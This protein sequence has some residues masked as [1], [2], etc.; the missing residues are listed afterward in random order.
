M[1][2]LIIIFTCLS[3]SV[4][5]RQADAELVEVQK[6]YDQ[7]IEQKDSIALR[8]LFHP[9]MIITGGDGTRRNAHSEIRDCVDPRYIVEYFRTS[10]IE[11]T[12]LDK[13]A[14]LRGDIEWQLKHGDQLMTLKRRITFT[15]MKIKGEWVI[16]A[17]HIGMQPRV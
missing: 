1:R 10:N 14:I 7:A 8:R 15:Y 17:Q 2:L 13:T 12:M 9:F 3:I 5:G 6:K 16:V 4:F 11:T